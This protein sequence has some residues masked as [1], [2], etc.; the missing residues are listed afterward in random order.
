M[1]KPGDA[2]W[3]YV[4]AIHQF[5]SSQKIARENPSESLLEIHVPLLSDSF[6]LI[7]NLAFFVTNKV[8]FLKK[9]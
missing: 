1:T 3:D 7:S 9:E 6:R 2:L 4:K 5:G 8:F